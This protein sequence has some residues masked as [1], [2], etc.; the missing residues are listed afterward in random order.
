MAK[1]YGDFIMVLSYFNILSATLYCPHIIHISVYADT[2]FK[3]N[4]Y[5]SDCMTSENAIC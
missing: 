3:L 5:I 4:V 1:Y 2:L